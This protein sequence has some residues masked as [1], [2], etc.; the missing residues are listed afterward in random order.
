[1][2]L[3]TCSEAQFARNRT[4]Q[5]L[6][7]QELDNPDVRDAAWGDLASIFNDSSMVFQ[8]LAVRCVGGNRVIPYKAEDGYHSI[9]TVTH[10]LDPAATDRPLRDGEWVK[11][12]WRAIKGILSQVRD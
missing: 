12:N 8:N 11:T 2:H 7:R 4:H 3:Y 9:A 10:D 6:M 1:M 5:G